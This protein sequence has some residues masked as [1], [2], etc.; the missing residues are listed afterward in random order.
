[1]TLDRECREDNKK[2]AGWLLWYPE[3]KREHEQKRELILHGSPGPPDGM[4]RGTELSDP[5]GI[6][7]AKLGDLETDLAWVRLVEEV[8]S[9]LPPKM[10]V[11]LR[12][13]REAELYKTGLRGRPGWVGHVQKYY[14][15]EMARANNRRPSDYWVEDR[16]FFTWWDRIVTYTVIRAAKRGML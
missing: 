12:L 10:Q 9:K 15:E 6:K 5:T 3:R 2:V 4:P 7:G 14:A 13:R 16:T 11:F 8:E 1:M